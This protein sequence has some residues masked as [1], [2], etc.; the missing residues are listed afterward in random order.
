MQWITAF[1]HLLA[2]L[3]V[4]AF[5]ISVC[6]YLSLIR[7]EIQRIN[8]HLSSIEKRFGHMERSMESIIANMRYKDGKK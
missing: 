2:T 5:C 6:I 7:R 8:I 4:P 3:L 1:V